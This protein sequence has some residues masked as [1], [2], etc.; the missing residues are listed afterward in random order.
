GTADYSLDL[1]GFGSSSDQNMVVL[2]DGVRLSENE[3]TPA[4]L[5]S[6]PVE[7][8]ERIEIVRGGS[9]VLY[10]EG[11]TGG[12]IQIITKRAKAGKLRGTAVAEAGSYGHREV[13][14]SLAGGGNGFSAD[15]NLS[16]Q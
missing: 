2:V 7:S 11:A 14:A 15:A 8:V 5:S 16:A 9:S 10:G 13:R 12:T 4:L 6:I 3:L 1:R